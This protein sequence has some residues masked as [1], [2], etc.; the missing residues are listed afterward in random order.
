VRGVNEEKGGRSY[1]P[2]GKEDLSIG[3]DSESTFRKEGAN[4]NRLEREG[5]KEKVL[6]TSGSGDKPGHANLNSNGSHS[7][8]LR[9]QRRERKGKEAPGA[10]SRKSRQRQ[11]HIDLGR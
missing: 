9:D 4:L 2:A 10:G 3:T 5:G 1:S 6:E 7:H 11:A 8:V